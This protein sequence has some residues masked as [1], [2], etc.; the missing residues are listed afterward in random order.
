MKKIGFLFLGLTAI[1]ACSKTEQLPSQSLLAN[2]FGVRVH[3]FTSD[4]LTKVTTTNPTT[5]NLR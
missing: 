5:F 1:L 4:V 2:T 3:D